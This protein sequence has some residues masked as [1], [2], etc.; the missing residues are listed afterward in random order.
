MALTKWGNETCQVVDD[1]YFKCW[2][3]LQD[4]FDPTN[5]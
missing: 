4:H 2:G 5:K 1:E 3:D